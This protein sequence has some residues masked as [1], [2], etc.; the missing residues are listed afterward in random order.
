MTDYEN[1]IRQFVT[2]AIGSQRKQIE[3]LF[4]EAKHIHALVRLR[5]RGLSGPKDRDAAMRAD[6]KRRLH[7]EWSARG[8]GDAFSLR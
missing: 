8:G 6:H 5:L 4:G 1:D 7:A 3:R 2:F